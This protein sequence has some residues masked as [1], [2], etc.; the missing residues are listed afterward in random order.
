MG[1]VANLKFFKLS[2]SC[3]VHIILNTLKKFAI[4]PRWVRD[5]EVSTER[6]GKDDR[7][8]DLMYGDLGA[9]ALR[10]CWELCESSCTE[11]RD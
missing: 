4:M 6:V 5:P 11:S 10:C 8:G 3:K 2:F 9:G 1:S 7:L